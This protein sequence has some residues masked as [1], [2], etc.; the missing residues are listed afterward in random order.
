MQPLQRKSFHTTNKIYFFTAPPR[1]VAQS[2]Y[3][4]FFGTIISASVRGTRN[5]RLVLLYNLHWR[6]CSALAV[7]WCQKVL[8]V[9]NRSIN[10]LKVKVFSNQ[11]ASGFT[12]TSILFSLVSKSSSGL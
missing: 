11:T 5:V 6:Q 3:K 7:H 9:F 8:A 12:Y 2:F 10:L 4:I 1:F